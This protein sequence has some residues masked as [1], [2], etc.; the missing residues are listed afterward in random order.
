MYSAIN[1]CL[2]IINKFTSIDDFYDSIYYDIIINN[3]IIIRDIEQKLDKNTK[4]AISQ[5]DWQKFAYYDKEFNDKL[6]FK[7]KKIIYSILKNELP[8]LQMT[9]E[10]IIFSK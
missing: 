6:E 7:D 9:L 4:M 3:L 2:T 1:K 8:E 10:K 5:I